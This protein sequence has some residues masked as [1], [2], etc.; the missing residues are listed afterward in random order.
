MNKSLNLVTNTQLM[1]RNSTAATA[2]PTTTTSNIVLFNNSNNGHSNQNLNDDSVQNGF[3]N[4]ESPFEACKNGNLEAVKRLIN[5]TNVNIKDKHGRKSTCLH[6]AAGFG[7]K[8]VCEYLL[9]ECGADP[10]IKDEGGLEPIHNAASFGHHE[11]VLLLIKYKANVNAKDNWCWTPLHEACLKNKLDVV[12]ALVRNHADISIK[13]LDGK[14]PLDLCESNSV[15]KLILSGEYGKEEILEA[16]RNGNQE[17]LIQLLTP[18]NVNCHASDGR[19]S[20]PLHLASG[21]NR[22]RIVKSKFFI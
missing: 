21:Y 3:L 22:T 4:E 12:V 5:C 1:N 11:V 13:N 19:R 18:L 10:S 17:K 6:F 9:S 15:I 14:A 2:S 20:S 16:A 7:R 8:D